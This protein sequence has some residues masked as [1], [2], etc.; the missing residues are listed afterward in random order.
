[1]KAELRADD[2]GTATLQYACN[3]SIKDQS[4]IFRDR[5]TDAKKL[6][7]FPQK[8]RQFS[9]GSSDLHTLV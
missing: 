7:Q 2:D 4:P 6:N 5:M 1:M 8:C 3:V 9:F